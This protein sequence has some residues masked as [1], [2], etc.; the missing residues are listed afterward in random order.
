MECV[1]PVLLSF[2][3]FFSLP[4]TSPLTIDPEISSPTLGFRFDIVQA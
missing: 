4:K 1:F 2:N 3:P